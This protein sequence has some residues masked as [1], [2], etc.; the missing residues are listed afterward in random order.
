MQNV[1]ICNK[2]CKC[3]NTKQ[4]SPALLTE[5]NPYQSYSEIAKTLAQITHTKRGRM[6]IK[7]KDIFDSA[8]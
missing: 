2:L 4:C 3:D 8:L 7:L 5:D 6:R 1:Y